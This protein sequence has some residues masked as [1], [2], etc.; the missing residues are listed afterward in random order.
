[1]AQHKRKVIVITGVTHGLGRAMTK[2]LIELNHTV[3]GCGRSREEIENLRQTHGE[4]HDFAMLDISHE[5]QVESWAARLLG[6]HGP[7]DLLIN[8]AAVI[9]P[10][11]PLWRVSREEFDRVIDVN[12]KGVANVL[13][14][15][16]PAMVARKSG[17]VVNI[18]SGWGRSTAPEVAPY[19]TTKWAIEGLTR[20][21]AQEVPKGMAAV[22]LNPGIIDTAML[23]SCFG[24]DAGHYPS[25]E[26]WSEQAVPFILQLGPRDNGKPLTAPS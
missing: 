2:K 22:P 10:N 18:S 26:D 3:L 25:A 24:E 19:C 13:R 16:L 12:I 11:A 20:A 1:M 21:L 4:P 17:V 15:F 6:S 8:N 23:R 5:D 14:Y 7:P 9:N